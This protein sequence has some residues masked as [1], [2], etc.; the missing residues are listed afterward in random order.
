MGEAERSGVLQSGGVRGAALRLGIAYWMAVCAV[1]LVAWGVMRVSPFASAV[2]KIVHYS[3]CAGVA[4]I[5]S[6]I[7]FHIHRRF[8]RSG[9]SEDALPLL[10]AASFVL[11]LLAAPLWAGL[12][13]AVHTVFVW[14]QPVLLDPEALGYDMG[15]G[16]GLMFGWACLFVT[17]VYAIELNE[18]KVRLAAV[19]EEALAAQMRAL[20]YQVNPHFLFNTL[21][22]IAGLIEE[23]SAVQAERMVLSLSTFLRLTLTLDPLQDVTLA[24]EIALQ[25]EYLS[26]EQARFSDRMSFSIDMDHEAADALVPSLLLQPLIENAIKH[27]VGS[28]RDK[29]DLALSAQRH[30]ERLHIAIE[31][32]M[33]ATTCQRP[34]G[35]GLGLANVRQRLRARFQEA[36]VLQSGPVGEGRFRVTLDL[37]WRLA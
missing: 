3:L 20:R 37:P 1:S 15:Y 34:A 26:I 14:P 17:V 33:P 7:L 28:A 6:W 27:G 36:G 22:S 30:G 21:N 2:A 8:I 19:R 4:A 10:V 12:G 11:S 13:F 31:N 9:S 29:V 35:I 18:R 16:G 25:Q 23:G 24:E 5:I 32:G